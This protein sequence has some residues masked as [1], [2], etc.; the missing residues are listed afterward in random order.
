MKSLTIAEILKNQTI[1][2]QF[3]FTGTCPDK[4]QVPKTFTIFDTNYFLSEVR[5]RFITRK[6]LV[7]EDNPFTDFCN[8]FTIWAASRGLM[9]ARIAYG[10]S[11]GYNPIEN[12]SSYEHIESDTDLEHGL[13][14]Q[15]TY[16]SDSVERT[17]N[18][19]AMTRLYDEDAMTRLYDQDL[20][21][22][23]YNDYKIEHTHDND[24]T[25]TT[26]NDVTD[27]GS[28]K[29]YGVNSSAA[30]PVTEDQ[31]IKSG[32]EDI[33]YSGKSADEYSGEF[34]EEHSGGYSDTH[35][36]GYSDTHSGGYTDEHSGGYT[37][38]NSGTD[39]TDFEQTTTKHGNIGVL[40]ASE[41]LGRE[42]SG[43]MQDLANRALCEFIDRYT[44]YCE[45]VSI[46][47]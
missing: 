41:M 40:T 47:S 43:L 29:K 2:N 19:D 45:G 20:M 13:E 46:W 16:N 23:G 34:T 4:E 15:R 24:K 1:T 17:Y 8:L 7:D 5:H 35:S 14:T 27:D 9:Y 42:Y 32:S 28:H 12:Y 39:S 25:T 31:N 22:H 11:L 26:F 10:Y 30:V 21:T 36:G 38:A 44:F 3:T 33:E 18:Q 6:V 37:D